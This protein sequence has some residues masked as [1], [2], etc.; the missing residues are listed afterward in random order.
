MTIASTRVTEESPHRYMPWVSTDEEKRKL[1][2]S[3]ARKDRALASH[4]EKNQKLTEDLRRLKSDL[5]R[6]KEKRQTLENE[7]EKTKK[8]RDRYRDMLFKRK[9]RG[10]Q[11]QTISEEAK[12]SVPKR[13]RG[14]QKG[15]NYHG[16]KRPNRVTQK[17]RLYLSKCPDCDT[18]LNR[19]KGAYVHHVEDIPAPEYL[20]TNVTKYEIEK[21]WCPCCSRIKRVRPAEVIP[22]SRYGIH[23]VLYILIQK[24]N[25]KSSL[26]AIADSLDMIFDL[27]ISKGGIVAILR[28][29][30]QHLGPEYDQLLKKLRAAKIK[31][32]DETGWRIEGLNHWIWGFFTNDIAYYRIEESRGKGV[33]EKVLDS[34]NES[35][36][37]VRDDY[38]SYAK[39]PVQHQSC[40]AHLLRKSREAKQ[41]EKASNDV[42]Q[43]HHELKAIFKRLQKIQTQDFDFSKR[44]KQH[45]SIQQQLELIMQR[46]YVSVDAKEIQT[47]ISNQGSNLI[48]AILSESHVPL[49]NNLAERQLRP[50]VVMRKMSGG[51]KTFDA[52]QIH[53]TIMSVLESIKLTGHPFLPTLKSTIL[54]YATAVH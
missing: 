7:L 19:A 16:Y 9:T 36:I 37:L 49:T 54:K 41:Y 48:T 2:Y 21:Q 6:E 38:A 23:T 44:K 33:P 51:S 32:A 10:E 24:Y 8:Q 43:L 40:W 14:G 18:R 42:K 13:N 17:K 4:R 35:D 12:A 5:D 30:Q 39:L 1:R 34:C 15:H 29:T 26:Q 3:I 27:K 31:H 11:A 25:A 20:K 47:R 52:A 53:M 45:S 22:R 50:L 46:S 28:K